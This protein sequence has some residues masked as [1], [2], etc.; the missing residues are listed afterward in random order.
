MQ[1]VLAG[2]YFFSR[3]GIPREKFSTH[4]EN[5]VENGEAAHFKAWWG[6][7]LTVHVWHLSG[8]YS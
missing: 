6:D 4:V 2:A 7:M 5:A 1:R 3:R 8:E